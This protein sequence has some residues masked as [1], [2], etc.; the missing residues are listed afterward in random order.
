MDAV[1][2]AFMFQRTSCEVSWILVLLL[3]FSSYQSLD[4]IFHIY[5]PVS[6]LIM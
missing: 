6:S 4:T 5:Y 3:P 1:W 2:A